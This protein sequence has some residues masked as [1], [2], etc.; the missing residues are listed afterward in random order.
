MTI[1]VNQLIKEKKTDLPLFRCRFP[2]VLF[3]EF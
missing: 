3:V 2:K 1:H